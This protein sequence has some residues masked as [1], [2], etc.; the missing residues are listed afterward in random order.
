MGSK[1]K[2][3]REQSPSLPTPLMH[4]RPCSTCIK[5]SRKGEGARGRACVRREREMKVMVTVS[6]G[7]KQTPVAGCRGT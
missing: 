3:S 1:K 6:I 2:E 5:E 7:V 4:P